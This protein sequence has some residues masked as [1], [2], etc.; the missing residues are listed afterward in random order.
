[1]NPP[2]IDQDFARLFQEIAAKAEGSSISKST[3]AELDEV[4]HFI[5]ILLKN[6]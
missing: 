1:M 3:Q 6:I 5:S 4:K 2:G